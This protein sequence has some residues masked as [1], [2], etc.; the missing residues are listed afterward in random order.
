MTEKTKG[1]CRIC[2]GDFTLTANG[3]IRSHGPVGDRCGGG[4]DLPREDA[5]QDQAA[6][7]SDAARARIAAGPSNGPNQ[8][9]AP[10]PTGQPRP[11]WAGVQPFHDQ[12]PPT[13]QEIRDAEAA[14][15]SGNAPYE[16]EQA[17]YN[18]LDAAPLTDP[19][20][21]SFWNG[22]APGEQPDEA[23]A[24]LASSGDD[25]ADSGGPSRW[26]PSRYDGD[27]AE[28]FAHFEAGEEIRR[29]E[30]GGYQGRE[31]CGDDLDGQL[32]ETEHKARPKA[33]QRKVPLV[34]GRY[35][36]P[37]PDNPSKAFR[38]SRVT[39]W[40]KAASD[41]FALSL[42]QQRAVLVGLTQDPG[43]LE[44][45]ASLVADGAARGD[46]P[47]VVVKKAKDVLNVLAEKAKS[48]AGTSERSAKGTALH[49]W[50]EQ[51]DAGR[52]LLDD[53]PPEHR[54]DVRAHVVGLAAAGIE[55]VPHL[56]ERTVA[57]VELGIMGTFDAVVR[58]PDGL[59][60]MADSKTGSL[61][62]N[63]D[64]IEA[65]L[66]VYARGANAHG[67]AQYSGEGDPKDW[68]NWTWVPLTDENGA[69]I[70]VEEDWGV[71]LHLPQGQAQMQ[72]YRVGLEAGWRTALLC[73]EIK[74]NQRAKH[75][76]A[77]LPVPDQD[78]APDGAGDALAAR[79]LAQAGIATAPVPGNPPETPRK[80][81]APQ[82]AHTPSGPP[83]DWGK[84]MAR[85]GSR[86]AAMEL[87][88]QARDAGFPQSELDAYAQEAKRVL[89]KLAEPTVPP[90]HERSWEADFSLVTTQEQ[91]EA[92]YQEARDAGMPAE[93]L[94]HCSRVAQAVLGVR[95]PAPEE[96]DWQ[97]L[98]C[99]VQDRDE[100]VALWGR[101]QSAGVAAEDMAVL[102]A[103]AKA[104][105]VA[106]RDG[107][108]ETYNALAAHT[109]A[110]RLSRERLEGL[111]AYMQKRVP[112]GS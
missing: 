99:A 65:Q 61:E 14:L 36:M 17:A 33:V 40:I 70:R 64:E 42:W 7:A 47:D 31:C 111:L 81:G 74:A 43:L 2:G 98:F 68:Q 19:D 75:L 93:D 91:A 54:E 26:F 32:E 34:G 82:T 110:G 38:G 21:A 76:F 67:I 101:A 56:M 79:V 69:Q 15:A 5:P 22:T 39:G 48:A 78:D 85:V 88:I 11:S 24:W 59:Y 71:V 77:P 44:A 104:V 9:R 4:S 62:Y 12:Q 37:H 66:A 72:P 102:G 25:A 41:H 97:V 108:R 92:L 89:A 6:T 49:K 105:L 1:I 8:H 96:H 84:E 27:C 57:V 30:D 103:I 95:A 13:D 35:V 16:V 28:C 52:T 18:I 10:L 83:R 45:V 80:A 55:P 94:E 112:A 90:V 60:R 63:R 87:W 3:R 107:A 29:T 51:V 106:D 86:D 50:A 46:R 100:A 53:V 20:E 58:M 73:R 23:D 109:A